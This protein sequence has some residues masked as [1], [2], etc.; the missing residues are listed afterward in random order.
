MYLLR[1]ELNDNKSL[2]TELKKVYGLSFFLIKRLCNNLGLNSSTL[3]KELNFKH[4]NLINRWIIKN[5]III[6]DDLKKLRLDSKQKLIAIKSYKGFRFESNLPVRGQRTK[7]NGRTQKRINGVLKLK[8]KSKN[9]L[10][11]QKIS[12]KLKK[13]K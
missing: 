6:N 10:S 3:L 9:K 2:R 11:Q 13:K 1:N 7:S 12:K 5:N 8:I 4:F